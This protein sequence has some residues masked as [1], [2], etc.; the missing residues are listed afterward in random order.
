MQIDKLYDFNVDHLFHQKTLAAYLKNQFKDATWRHVKKWISNKQVKVN[1]RFI[2]SDAL[3]LREGDKVVLLPPKGSQSSPKGKSEKL[4]RRIKILFLDDHLVVIEKPSG[5]S[6]IRHAHESKKYGSRVRY[7]PFTVADF[8]PQLIFTE[9]G[10]KNRKGTLPPVKAVHRLDKETSGIMVYARTTQSASRLG[11]QFKAHTIERDYQ[12]FCLGKPQTKRVVSK[13]V[14]N[15]GDGIRGSHKTEGKEAITNVEVL[16]TMGQV[17]QVKCSLETGR[18]HQIRIHLS[19][20]GCPVLGETVYVKKTLICDF[21]FWQKCPRL[22]LHASHLS[23]Q[24]PFTKNKMVF[25]SPLPSELVEFW[26]ML[27]KQ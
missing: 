7:L 26:N 8:L 10:K 3:R 5:I 18:T 23:F 12:A 17:S 25:S 15:R 24:H 13:L 2:T 27:K 22:A 20:M 19:E 21:E 4:G 16:Q 6:S 1:K 9:S 11:A 14:R